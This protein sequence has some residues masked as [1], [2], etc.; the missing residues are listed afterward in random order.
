MILVRIIFTYKFTYICMCIYIY[1]HLLH[2]SDQLFNPFERKCFCIFLR[3]TTYCAL[4]HV[5]PS[6]ILFY[7]NIASK[8]R[9]YKMGIKVI[10]YQR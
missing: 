1:M 4:K 9:V 3:F 6:I 5:L 10:V 2:Y 8:I 7:G